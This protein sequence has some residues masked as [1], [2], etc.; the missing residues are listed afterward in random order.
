MANNKS[1]NSHVYNITTKKF[2]SND[3]NSTYLW[4]CHLG[5]I[6]E[7]SIS[8]LHQV[9]LLNSFY[10]ESYDTCE[11]YLLGKM[12]K[13]PFTGHS[14]RANELLDLI[15]TDVCGPL[16]SDA[17]GGYK[18]FITFTDDFSRYVYVYLM[19]H[20]SE[21]FEMFKSFQ[22]EVQNQLGKTIK[23][24][25]SDQGGEYLSQEFD[26]HLRTC[27]IISQLTPLGTP[28]WNGVSER[29]NRTL[30]DMVRSM[31]SPTDLPF[32]FWGY[33]L[34]TAAFTLNRVPSKAVEK[35]PYEIWTG[36]RPSLSFLKIWGC[37]A[38]V[39]CQVSNKL[40]P[41][42]DKC[43]FM[44]YP[45]ETKG[46]Y[47]YN[48]IE[49]KVFVAW[50]VVFLEREFISKGTSGS[51]VQLEEVREPQ[52]N[53]ELP[54]DTHS[55]QTI[56]DTPPIAQNLR[57]YDRIRH[58]PERYGFLVTDNH[59]VLLVD[60]NEPTTY[61]EAMLDPDSKKWLEAMKSEIQSMYDNQVWTLI[62]PPEGTKTI[63][64]K[65]VFK[66][67]T[68]MDGKVHT[69]KAR[70]VAKGFKQIHGIDYDETFSPV[71]MLKSIRILIAI[72]AYHDYEI[73]KMDVKTTFLN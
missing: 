27:G 59:D 55:Q 62:D 58:E 15:H 24:L 2:K 11:S 17:R 10:F 54:V 69:Y 1:N 4:H 60:Q 31:M 44:G 56:V 63:G 70:L 23:A 65:W 32:T 22:N 25:R 16:R 53:I 52:D 8:K 34:E 28:Q 68:Y 71:A 57:R 49:N 41:K 14:E 29:R 72:A 26:G 30:L 47:F 18:Y 51:K 43:L 73:W 50:N 64:C 33:A 7:K 38:Y 21:S 6:N 5:H 42:S 13:D 66:K 36:K 48:P 19:R 35:T 61:Q 67:K 9:G 46:Y 12:T 3:L 39:K 40:E 20:K 37:E 45:K